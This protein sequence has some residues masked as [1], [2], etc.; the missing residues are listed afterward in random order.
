MLPNCHQHK[1]HWKVPNNPSA[2]CGVTPPVGQKTTSLN[3][4]PNDFNMEIPPADLRREKLLNSESRDPTDSLL[5]PVSRL[6]G[7]NGNSASAHASSRAEVEPGETPK[8]APCIS[9]I[10]Q[11]LRC[12]DCSRPYPHIGFTCDHLNGLQEHRKCASVISITLIPPRSKRIRQRF[13]ICRVIN[14][15]DRNDRTCSA[16][17]L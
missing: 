17:L 4:P 1:S 7:K 2:F 16:N 6:P 10:R 15:N 13:G 12:Q 11:V 5:R 9:C 14:F 3:G 8:A